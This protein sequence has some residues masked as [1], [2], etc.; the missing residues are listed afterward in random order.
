VAE[1]STLDTTT[2]ARKDYETNRQTRRNYL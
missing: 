1:V 2:E